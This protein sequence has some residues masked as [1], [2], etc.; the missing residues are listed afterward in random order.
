MSETN[1]GA[2]NADEI[3]DDE[4][5][6]TRLDREAS[7]YLKRSEGRS[8]APTTSVRQAVQDDIAHGRQWARD[9]ASASRDA[10][11]EQPLISAAYAVGI[12]VLI[13]LLLRR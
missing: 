5:P 6:T 1:G 10:I 7:D 12:G 11:V 3:H 8:F 13:G 9:K 4:T 2:A